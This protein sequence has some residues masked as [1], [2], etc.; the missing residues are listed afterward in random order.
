[1]HM[2]FISMLISAVPH[3]PSLSPA[4]SQHTHGPQP[5]MLCTE[6]SS[7]R[8]VMFTFSSVNKVLGCKTVLSQE[9]SWV[10]VL[11][12]TLQ[13][14]RWMPLRILVPIT[15]QSTLISPRRKTSHSQAEAALILTLMQTGL[16][17]HS[18]LATV[19][20]AM[21]EPHCI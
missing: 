12:N 10:S 11:K 7:R 5:S 4:P 9:I 21:C 17:T 14:F 20:A 1:M 13:V 15:T 16:G 18:D 2:G 6:A 8:I 19:A 3:D